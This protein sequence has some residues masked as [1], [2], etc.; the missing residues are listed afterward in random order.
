MTNSGDG[1]PDVAS[2]GSLVE[3]SRPEWEQEDMN[4]NL[5]AERLAISAKVWLVNL[6][7]L[8]KRGL[9]LL[10]ILM[11]SYGGYQL[12]SAGTEIGT[13]T[14]LD[15]RQAQQLLISSQP[16]SFILIAAGLV[17]AYLSMQ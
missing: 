7:T 8:L 6:R 17:L 10:S 11:V 4:S 13:N 16:L 9:Q 2:D 12:L 14:V 3:S 1:T 5:S 15:S